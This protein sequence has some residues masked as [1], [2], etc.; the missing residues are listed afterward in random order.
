MEQT[1]NITL[2]IDAGAPVYKAPSTINGTLMKLG[3][4]GNYI[5]T[6][7]AIKTPDGSAVADTVPFGSG[8]FYDAKKKNNTAFLGAPTANTPE[9]VFAGIVI[10]SAALQ[11]TYPANGEAAKGYNRFNITKD[12]YI[13]YRTSKNTSGTAVN[14]DSA[15]VK[16]GAAFLIKAADGSTAVGTNT[17]GF[18]KVG[19]IVQL[20]P[21][22][23]SFV[24]KI[25]AANAVAGA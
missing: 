25:D 11:G 21:D 14:F 24:V 4:N 8:V 20:N 17:A 10:R 16:V 23:K 13:I 19:T 18:Y 12:G 6:V 22:D 15:E 9:V 7:A 1:D 3:V 2:S 5:T